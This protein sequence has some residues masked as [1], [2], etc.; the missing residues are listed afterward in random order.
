M[1]GWIADNH[2]MKRESAF[3]INPEHVFFAEI[4]PERG[5]KTA[6]WRNAVLRR[7]SGQRTTANVGRGFVAPGQSQQRRPGAPQFTGWAIDEDL[8]F[9]LVDDQEGQAFVVA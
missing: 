4:L 5:D 8:R 6:G 2:A 7:D 3:V 1:I 9:A